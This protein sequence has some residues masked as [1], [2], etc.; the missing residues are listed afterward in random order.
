[1]DVTLARGINLRSDTIFIY[2]SNDDVLKYKFNT[3]EEAQVVFD[4]ISKVTG[5]EAVDVLAKPKKRTLRKIIEDIALDEEASELFDKFWASYNKKVSKPEA[6][7]SWGAL[8]YE[9]MDVAIV[10]AKAYR[11]SCSG[12]LKYMKNPTTWLNQR[13][14][15]DIII[16]QD[17]DN[18]PA[19]KTY[20]KP[21]YITN[22]R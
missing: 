4:N 10:K 6:K 13:C 14:W 19:K 22:D 8:S 12:R 5:A 15:E 2:Y 21:K 9:E 18:K 16:P 3:S 17:E 11:D 7:R 20:Q 1:V